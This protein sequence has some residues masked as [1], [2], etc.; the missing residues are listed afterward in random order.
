MYKYAVCII[1]FSMCAFFCIGSFAESERENP[2]PGILYISSYSPTHEFSQK[3][4]DGIKSVF[5]DKVL[6]E[7]E[8]L[9][10]DVADKEENYR[11]LYEMIEL[12]SSADVPVYD[13]IIVGGDEALNAVLSYDNGIFCNT[14][15][16]LS[17]VFNE[18]LVERALASGRQI[19]G[20]VEELWIKE[21]LD[22]AVS[23][24]QSVKN[25]AV[26]YDNSL[27]GTGQMRQLYQ[28]VLDNTEY[29]FAG[30]NTSEMTFDEIRDALSNLNNETVLFYLKSANKTNENLSGEY[31]FIRAVSNDCGIPMFCLTDLNIGSGLLEGIVK[32]PG[33]DGENS[34]NIAL[35]FLDE[36]YEESESLKENK[37]HKLDYSVAEKYGLED[38]MYLKR[39]K[40]VNK[41]LSF[42]EK[43][44]ERLAAGSLIVMIILVLIQLITKWIEFGIKNRRLARSTADLQEELKLSESS[45]VAKAE[46]LNSVS[47]EI[48]EPLDKLMNIAQQ[49]KDA[50]GRGENISE[51]VLRI[52][53]LTGS[54]YDSFNEYLSISNTDTEALEINSE[55]FKLNELLG[56]IT[57]SY[58]LICSERN[59]EFGF[60]THD[61][62]H[63]DLI[64]DL[65][66]LNLLISNILSN[67]IKYTEGGKTIDFDVRQVESGLE[68]SAEFEF[69]VSDTGMGMSDEKVQAIFGGN[70]LNSKSGIGVGLAMTKHYVSLMNGAIAAES[71]EGEGTVVTLRLPF[72]INKNE[73]SIKAYKSPDE[74]SFSGKKVLVAEDNE[75][76]LA[77]LDEILKAVKFDTVCVRDGREAVYAFNRACYDEFDAIILDG[78]MPVMDGSQAANTIRKCAHANSSAIPIIATIH[79]TY[80]D[81]INKLLSSGVNKY[82]FKP[83]DADE[84]Y[85]MMDELL[86]A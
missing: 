76:N 66:K 14:P 8:Y 73:K 58:S 80:T 59:I 75:L 1:A 82:I 65:Y 3:Q 50:L 74:Y 25:V 52:N 69:I 81:D 15:I 42:R 32:D 12:H 55:P 47:K 33:I 5:G 53:E 4:I 61:I 56:R 71:C 13:G 11:I 24:Y 37:V 23:I 85:A 21:N 28:Y 86:K 35:G 62:T 67:A 60:K 30:I 7:S 31:E 36:N 43:Y 6:L 22:F 40:Y 44:G 57:K 79:D 41:E 2:R 77:I 54:L 72:K 46:Y 78:D 18:E 63:N 68:D 49:T 45:G 27:S 64:G 16:V 51:N 83:I 34:A 38:L 19:F 17:G 39:V 48:R 70:Y 29:G 84:L 10:F 26:V 20:S 9:Y